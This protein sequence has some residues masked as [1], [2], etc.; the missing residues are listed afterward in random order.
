MASGDATRVWFPEVAEFLA[1]RWQPDWQAEG[2]WADLIELA[3]DLDAMAQ[4][5]RRQ[6]GIQAPMMTCRGCN[7]RQRSAPP[8]ISVSSMIA[9]AGRFGLTE[10]DVATRL[11]RR[12]QRYRGKIGLDRHGRS[13]SAQ[14]PATSRQEPAHDGGAA[15]Q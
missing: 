4:R 5:I 12:W 13:V 14:T 6:G 7:V 10:Q 15:N 8:Q 1:S 2:S 9:A 3:A 11:R